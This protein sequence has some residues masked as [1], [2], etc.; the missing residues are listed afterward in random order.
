MSRVDFK[1]NVKSVK[2]KFVL[3]D[4][5]NIFNLWKNKYKEVYQY[6]LKN[7]KDLDYL[8][9]MLKQKFDS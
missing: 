9:L 3:D 5:K 2:K 1:G 6:N 8:I 7:N 4:P